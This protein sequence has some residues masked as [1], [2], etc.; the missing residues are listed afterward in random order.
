MKCPATLTASHT[1][2]SMP[3]MAQREKAVLVGV[4]L[5]GLPRTTVDVHLDELAQLVDTAGGEEVARLVQERASPDPATFIG[6]GKLEEAA[7]L[8][9]EHA[10]GLVVFDDDLSPAQVRHIENGLPAEV[11]VLDRA[12]VILDIFASRARTREAQTQV[13]LAQLTYTLSRLTRRWTHLSRQAGGIGTRGVGETQI[14]TDRRMIRRRVAALRDRLA[15]MEQ[16]RAVQRRRREQL[17]GL[18]LV[19]YTNAGKSTLFERLTGSE[20][21]VEDR[22]FATLDPRVRRADLGD[23]LVVTVADTVGFIR[24]LPHHLVASFRATLSEAARAQVVCH[25]LDASHPEWNAHLQVGDG[26]LETLGI[27]PR[28]CVLAY[29]KIDRVPGLLPPRP[30]ER[31]GVALSALTGEGV[32][33]LRLL[34]RQQ[35]LA[36]PGLETLTFPPEG[37]ETLQRALQ[38]EM[39]VARRFSASGIELVVRRGGGG[40]AR[41]NGDG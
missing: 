7:A 40:P 31:Q 18:A 19:G 11:K 33:H 28:A 6:R 26:V 29:N 39:V 37:G 1:H 5:A 3:A 38:R 8:V 9:R 10:A 25:V 20:T 35:V 41:S 17:P 23:G 30:P 13:E 4:A 16:E 21:L 14:E 32:G 15:D 12:G 2:R 24:K 22:L 27:N 34:L 36:Q